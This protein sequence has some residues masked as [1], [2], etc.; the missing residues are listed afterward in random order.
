MRSV[1]RL[2]RSILSIL[3]RPVSLIVFFSGLS[4]IRFCSITLGPL[5]TEGISLP[6]SFGEGFFSDW[7]FPTDS[8]INRDG[9]FFPSKKTG[10]SIGGPDTLPGFRNGFSTWGILHGFLLKKESFWTVTTASLTRPLLW[11]F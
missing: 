3:F 6:H 9:V 7:T 1:C 11:T 8:L 10:F 2:G 4:V 5:S